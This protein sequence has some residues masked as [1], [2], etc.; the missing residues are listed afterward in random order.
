MSVAI[1]VDSAL[2]P[3]NIIMVCG[4]AVSFSWF[5]IPFQGIRAPLDISVLMDLVFPG[6]IHVVKQLSAE[7]EA[8][9]LLYAVSQ[10]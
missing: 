10:V 4:S 9:R 7:I 3:M 6:Q 2:V 8:T 5:R 1:Q